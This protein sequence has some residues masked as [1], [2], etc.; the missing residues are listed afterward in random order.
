MF[1]AKDRQRCQK[2][3]DKYYVGTRFH[4]TINRGKIRSTVCPERRLLDA[5]CGRH[6]RFAMEFSGIAHFVG[7]DLD[8]ALSTNNQNALIGLYGDVSRLLFRSECF[9][10]VISRSVVEHLEDPPHVFREFW[11]VLR[12]GGKAIIVTPNKY[13]YVSLIAA[14]TPDRLHRAL[15]SRIFQIPADGVFPTLYRA[16]TL[17]SISKGSRRAGFN[18]PLYLMFSPVLV[19]LCLLYERLASLEALRSVCG[20]IWAV[21]EKEATAGMPAVAGEV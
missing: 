1:R 14:L 19:R 9:D 12:P 5:G 11:G 13:D 2:L 10:V 17:S 8:P 4:G 16:N 18:Y 3:Y 20:S 6:M 15:V 7:I 21:F